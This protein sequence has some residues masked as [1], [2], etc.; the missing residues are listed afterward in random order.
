MGAEVAAEEV[1]DEAA[2]NAA[3]QPTRL[4]KTFQEFHK[5]FKTFQDVSHISKDLLRLY[6]KFK[7][8]A[9]MKQFCEC[10]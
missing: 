7:S 8:H 2:N 1:A 4:F 9:P 5:M 10:F 3:G 6:K